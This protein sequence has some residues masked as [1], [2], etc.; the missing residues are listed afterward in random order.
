[1]QQA[2]EKG[3]DLLETWLILEFCDQ[4]SFD[5]AIRAGRYTDNLVR[6]AVFR[7]MWS[8]YE[9]IQTHHES[10]KRGLALNSTRHKTNE[11]QVARSR[12]LSWEH[13]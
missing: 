6:P 11:A 13:L 3:A 7:R 2:A 8:G 10:V 12:A 4:G 5:H 1:M 9:G